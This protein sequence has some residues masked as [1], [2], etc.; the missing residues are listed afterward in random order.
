MRDLRRWWQYWDDFWFAPTGTFHLGLFRALIGTCMFIMYSIRLSDFDFL[1]GRE[2]FRPGAQAWDLLPAYMTPPMRWFPTDISIL[3][4][5]HWVFVIGLG[6][7]TVGLG[8]RILTVALFALQ[9]GFF[10]QNFATAYGA[11]L[12][13]LHWLL[14]LSLTHQ[15]DSFSV[16]NYWRRWRG[17]AVQIANVQ[18][19][20]LTRVG[21]RFV[22]IQ[23]AL[24][25]AFSGVEKLKGGPWWE[26]T[27]VWVTLTNRDLV[28]YDFSFLAQWPL[29]AF[30][31]SFL[32]LVWEIYFPFLVISKK[33]RAWALGFG[34]IF[35][36]FIGWLM[37]LPFFA[38]LMVS[39][40]V[41]FWPSE[42]VQKVWQ[43]G[44]QTFLVG[45]HSLVGI[46]RKKIVRTANGD[47]VGGNTL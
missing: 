28:D 32:P 22:Q 14:Y 13:A 25:Y 26:G 1:F 36:F 19:G 23:L 12:I 35:H 44:A 8:G 37:N 2:S 5:L 30:L 16:L 3:Y 18:R 9:V 20:G 34:V 21:L 7:W 29:V 27:A 31:A 4:G 43:W 24:I 11:D 45:A 41:L 6:L 33:T 17:R 10:Q 38:V 39:S 15:S 40:Y 46:F 42:A 47:L